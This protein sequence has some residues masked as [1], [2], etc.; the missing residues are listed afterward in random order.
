MGNFIMRGSYY[1]Q[2]Q[3]F[4]GLDSVS[5]ALCCFESERNRGAHSDDAHHTNLP[6]HVFYQAFSNRK[7]QTKTVAAEAIGTVKALEN[8]G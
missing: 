3:L 8:V 1:A 7:P 6:I 2:R 4:K 5:Q